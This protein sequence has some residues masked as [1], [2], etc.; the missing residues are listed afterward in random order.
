MRRGDK[1][2]QACLGFANRYGLLGLQF[3]PFKTPSGKLIQAER[4]GAWVD[5]I[6][7]MRRAVH[8]W[9]EI[10]KQEEESLLNHLRR[11]RP[12]GATLGRDTVHFSGYKYEI[13]EKIES[14]DVLARARLVLSELLAQK[15]RDHASPELVPDE[16][17]KNLSLRIVPKNLLGAMW[18]QFARTVEGSRDVRQCSMCGNWMFISPDTFRTNRRYCSDTCRVRTHKLRQRKAREMRRDGSSLR[19]IAKELDTK[20]EIV[21]GWVESV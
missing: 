21:K 13:A 7:A 10:E 5:E 11:W 20:M 4:V 17:A 3:E 6:D 14:G 16:R 19:Q 15:L 12:S 2:S 9:E 8:L 1:H 18:L